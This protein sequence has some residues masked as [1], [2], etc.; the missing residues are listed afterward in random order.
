[1]NSII[2]SFSKDFAKYMWSCRGAPSEILNPQ[3]D[4]KQQTNNKCCQNFCKQSFILEVQSVFKY[5]PGYHNVTTL[6]LMCGL[7][8]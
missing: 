7:C 1:M 3:R 4:S 5:V 6:N 2:N 8:F